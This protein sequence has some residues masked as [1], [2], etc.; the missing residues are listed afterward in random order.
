MEMWF[1]FKMPFIVVWK[2]WNITNQS[3][4]I[5]SCFGVWGIAVLYEIFK[6]LR[7]IWINQ[8]YQP[9]KDE[10]VNQQMKPGIGGD[11]CLEDDEYPSSFKTSP[12]FW[13]AHLVQSVLFIIQA[14]IGY[15]L[16][17]IVMT[18]NVWLV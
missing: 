6:V 15:L 4:L 10:P 12:C 13:F 5:G 8:M 18:Y 7:Q 1:N 16:M 11:C 14:F 17:L 2:T 3:E 9:T